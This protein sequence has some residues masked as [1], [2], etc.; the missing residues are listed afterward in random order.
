MSPCFHELLAKRAAQVQQ[1][2]SGRNVK[3]DRAAAEL[4]TAGDPGQATKNVMRYPAGKKVALAKLANFLF[5][6]KSQ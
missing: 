1:A 5:E 3:M 2:R 4:R 6:K